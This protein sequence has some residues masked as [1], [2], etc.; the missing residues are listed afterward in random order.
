MSEG[1]NAHEIAKNLPPELRGISITV[2]ERT[3]STNTRMREL[4]S[5]GAEHMSLLCAN[6]QTA[7]RGRR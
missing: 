3:D 7:G 6:E 5:L 4:A 2:L 1:L